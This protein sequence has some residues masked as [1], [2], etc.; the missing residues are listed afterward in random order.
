MS[1]Y[2]YLNSGEAVRV[3]GK[4]DGLIAGYLQV[5][6]AYGDEVDM[7]DGAAVLLRPSELHDVP[8]TLLLDERVTKLQQTVAMMEETIRRHRTELAKQERERADHKR[9]LQQSQAWLDFEGLMSGRLTHRAEFSAWGRWAI[10]DITARVGHSQDMLVL[11]A[12]RKNDGWE[13]FWTAQKTRDHREKTQ[14]FENVAAAKAWVEAQLAALDLKHI[15]L[16]MGREIMAKAREDGIACPTHLAKF[17]EA[18]AQKKRD[19][20]LE[21]LR[22]QMEA[23]EQK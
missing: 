3:I 7:G 12:K 4:V 5:E 21:R 9:W 2:K 6:Y 11:N 14:L 8:P 17:V 23:L 16:R 19:E 20:E 13:W 22:A 15:D 10:T 1:E 18:E